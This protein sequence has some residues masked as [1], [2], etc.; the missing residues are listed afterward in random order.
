MDNVAVLEAHND[1]IRCVALHPSLPYLLSTSDDTR[2]KIWNW[3]EGWNCIQIFKGHTQ[4]VM[5]VAF[6]PTDI[7]T[8][9]SASIDNTIKIWSLSSPEP[10]F[11]LDG[12]HDGVTCIDYFTI[13]D[14]LYLISGSCDSTA[15]VWDYQLKSCIQTLEGHT[16]SITTIGCHPELPLI[17]S[18]SEDGMICMWHSKDYRLE[19]TINYG[20]QRVWALAFE[21][22]SRSLMIIGYDEGS[23]LIKVASEAPVV[24]MDT[25]GKIIWAKH[26]NIQAVNMKSARSKIMDLETIPLVVK[27]LGSC[28]IYPQKLMHSPDSR[29]VAICGESEYIVYSAQYLKKRSFGS[30]LD[31]VW[32]S[33]SEYAVRESTSCVKI[34]SKSFKERTTV[35]PTFSAERL[36]GGLLLA[37]CSEGFICFHDWATGRLIIKVAVD[38]KVK[39][40]WWCY[41]R[42][43]VAISSD[44]SLFILKY[45]R[46]IVASRLI[47]EKPVDEKVIDGAFALQHEIN[48]R[49]RTGIWAGPH[50]I[51]IDASWRLNRCIGS[52]ATVLY[53]LGRPM[54]LLGFVASQSCIYLMDQDLK[55]MACR[56]VR[57][58]DKAEDVVGTVLDK[59]FILG[60]VDTPTTS[61]DT[62][63]VVN[64]ESKNR[65]FSWKTALLHGQYI[66]PA[67][68]DQGTSPTCI[69]NALCAAAEIE[70]MRLAA[71]KDPP[72]SSDIRFSVSSFVSDYENIKGL[73]PNEEDKINRL[74]NAI[75]LFEK[76]GVWAEEGDSIP[77]R[78]KIFSEKIPHKYCKVA[79]MIKS[80]RPVVGTFKID[81]SFR[82]LKPNDIYEYDANDSKKNQDGVTCAHCVVFVGY[83]LREGRT[84]LVFLNSHGEG[85][86]EDGFGRVYFEHVRN[87]TA[88]GLD[89][90]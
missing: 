37:I 44:S 5:H 14:R 74:S 53:H 26:N 51:F 76:E 6:N 82:D 29:H 85:F 43:Q 32:S 10:K 41:S 88:I 27:E 25:I 42:D 84:Y 63:V 80:G 71:L 83:G 86:G 65:E 34:F 2:I 72:G 56:F 68:R 64:K 70:S 67:V 61:V 79:R 55:V 49:A 45:H 15:K 38:F 66:L 52:K 78:Q 36:F 30:A 40:I 22:G 28:S 60:K 87:L 8:F 57:P 12:H 54:Y 47:D 81:S 3:D 59:D 50:F 33:E 89:S 35:S 19:T 21:K 39:N 62:N 69:F 7:N 90:P 24:S 18:G 31:L 9:A 75:K 13:G 1:C 77:R 46:E 73:L 16:R 20:L 4:P 17:V 23:I 11:T 48:K 58:T